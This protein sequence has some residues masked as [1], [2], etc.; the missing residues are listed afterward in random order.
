VGKNGNIKTKLAIAKEAI[1][2]LDQAQERRNPSNA[3]VDFRGRIKEIYLGLLAMEKIRARQR[4]RLTNVKFGDVSS[5][6]FY[7]RVNSR[8]RKKHWFLSMRKKQKRQK[9]ISAK[10]SA[11]SDQ[12]SSQLGGGE[13]GTKLSFLRPSRPRD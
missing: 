11:L 8:K 9:D 6:L 2:L 4:A 13:G 3:E 7:L 5:K 12:D 1:W 10:C